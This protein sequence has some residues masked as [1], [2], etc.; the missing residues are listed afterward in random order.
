MMFL[1]RSF[2][3]RMALTGAAA[4]T[5]LFVSDAGAFSLAPM[6]QAR[7][8]SAHER[9]ISGAW[10]VALTD[11]NR[12]CRLTLREEPLAD[13]LALVMPAGCKRALPRLAGASL[14]QSPSP[15]RVMLASAAGMAVLD[16]QAT[17]EGSFIARGPQGE[18]Y[19]LA[20]A[21][22]HIRAALAQ[23]V[24]SAPAP[25]RPAGF[26]S[27]RSRESFEPPKQVETAQV[28][29]RQPAPVV[30]EIRVDARD[31]PGRYAVL[32]EEG[33]DSGCLVTLH[34][35]GRAQLAPACL[36]RGLRIFD[37]VRWA[38]NRGQIVLTARRG[39]TLRLAPQANGLWDKTPAD[40]AAFSFRKI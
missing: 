31:V 40:G 8:A 23:P 25:R 1:G 26:Q 9:A 38:F 18:T 6:A 10:D 27:L 20:P 28:R 17:A 37:P 29:P 33:R 21:E 19:S 34:A 24:V 39:H 35:G 4:L 14:W 3:V 5:A 7:D 36:D 16:F 30:N 13:D 11:Q 22:D 2:S 12:R 15:A 32:R